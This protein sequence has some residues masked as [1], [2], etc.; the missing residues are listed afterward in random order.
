MGATLVNL[1]AEPIFNVDVVT[2]AILALDNPAKLLLNVIFVIGP[3]GLFISKLEFPEVIVVILPDPVGPVGPIDPSFPVGPVFPIDPL[4]PVGPIDPS[5][6]VGP[7]DPSFPVG[8][9]DPI[10]PDGIDQ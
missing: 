5:F 4:F 9:V 8:P 7:I 1:Y 10:P 3:V 6:P 2:V